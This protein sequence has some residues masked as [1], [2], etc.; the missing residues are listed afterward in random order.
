MAP[1]G[2]PV[3]TPPCHSRQEV[4]ETFDKNV[5]AARAAIAGASDEHLFKPWVLL[6]NGN[7]LLSLPRGGSTA[8]FCDESHH[9]SSGPTGSL[10]PTQR[11]SRAVD[12][13]A[14]SGRSDVR[15]A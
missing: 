13:W 2:K 14:V 11:R 4:L 7:P 1:G 5:A 3:T 9:P 10:P 15:L 6:R 8:E 12:I